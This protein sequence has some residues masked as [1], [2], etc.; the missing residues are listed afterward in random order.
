MVAITLSDALDKAWDLTKRHGLL[1]VVVYLII[2]IISQSLSRMFMP[3][4]DTEAVLEAIQNGDIVEFGKLVN[5][6]PLATIVL[7]IVGMSLGLGFINLVLCF[8]KETI[9]SISIDAWK[10]PI[11]VYVK[12]IVVGWI[13]GILSALG[14]I[15][16]IIPGI[17]VYVRLMFAQ[18]RVIDHPE[19]GVKEVLAASWKMTEGN[20]LN[21]IWLG[22][23]CVFILILGFCLCCVGALPAAVLISF[24]SVVAY[25]ILSGWYNHPVEESN[26]QILEA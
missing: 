6:N 13:V 19:E 9:T 2:Q 26:E 20:V 15:F 21:L 1:L 24:V 11:K 7:S 14:F 4:V 5:T 25:L 8:A 17:Y 10:M 16:C 23:V 18:T 22:I 12:Y 3:T